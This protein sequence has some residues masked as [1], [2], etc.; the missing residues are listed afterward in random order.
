MLYEAL[1]ELEKHPDDEEL[2]THTITLLEVL[3]RWLR[4]GRF[5]PATADDLSPPRYQK[6]Q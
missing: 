6:E 1:Q 3:T 4:M 5:P 2:R